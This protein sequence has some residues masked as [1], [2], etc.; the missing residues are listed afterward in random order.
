MPL[1]KEELK[2]LSPRERLKKLKEVEEETKTELEEAAAL[3]K[4]TEKEVN[5]E[6]ISSGVAVPDTQ[7]I[8]ISELFGSS[9]EGKKIEDMLDV[10]GVKYEAGMDDTDNTGYLSLGQGGGGGAKLEDTF[11]IKTYA[12]SSQSEAKKVTASKSLMDQVKKYSRG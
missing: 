12:A 5:V 4:E 10:G 1:N 8:D 3:I 7:P 2:K 9:E 11:D 6:D